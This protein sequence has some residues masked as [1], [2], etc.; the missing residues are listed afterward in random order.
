MRAGSCPRGGQCVSQYVRAGTRTIC[1][2]LE[3]DSVYL[4]HV[5]TVN[6]WGVTNTGSPQY[7]HAGTRTEVTGH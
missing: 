2:Y 3:E 4:P 1:I 6:R 5:S 7:V